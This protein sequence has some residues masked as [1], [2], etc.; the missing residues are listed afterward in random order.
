MKKLL[1]L[2]SVFLILSCSQ[3]KETKIDIAEVSK[4]MG[5]YS[6]KDFEVVHNDIGGGGVRN[7][8]V[9]LKTSDKSES[10][11]NKINEQIRAHYSTEKMNVDIFDNKKASEKSLIYPLEGTDKKLVA[12]HY[13]ATYT[14]ETPKVVWMYPLKE[15]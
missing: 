2:S 1:L 15:K 14:F 10:N 11:L 12:K 3:K 13:I 4:E 7:I 8:D 6:T 5:Y 9:L